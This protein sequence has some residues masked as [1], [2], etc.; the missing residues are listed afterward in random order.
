L[1]CCS[2]VA[3]ESFFT[4]K[5]PCNSQDTWRT[6]LYPILVLFRRCNQ[7]TIYVFTSKDHCNVHQFFFYHIIASVMASC[8]T[9][10]FFF[11]AEIFNPQK[12]KSAKIKCLLFRPKPQKLPVIRYTIL[13]YLSISVFNQITYIITW[14]ITNTTSLWT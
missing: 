12:N 7:T 2:L 14:C 11:A 10:T 6:H 5:K 3:T 13:L 4:C 1:L 8:N 9:S